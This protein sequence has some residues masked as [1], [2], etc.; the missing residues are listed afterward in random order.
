MPMMMQQQHSPPPVYSPDTQ[1][2]W[3]RYKP[4]LPGEPAHKH[5]LPGDVMHANAQGDNNNNNN[6]GDDGVNRMDSI[7]RTP[8]ESYPPTDYEIHHH[9]YH[10]GSETSSLPF[11]S[12]QSTGSTEVPSQAVGGHQRTG[13]TN[14]DPI[15]EHRYDDR[16]Y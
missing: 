14:M 3:L 13:S 4:E 8:H 15:S 10:R 2:G 7:Q 16:Q 5:E 11:V 1:N 9:H 12:P 6:G